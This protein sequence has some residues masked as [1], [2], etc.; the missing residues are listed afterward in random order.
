M[1]FTN[2]SGF[3]VDENR[4]VTGNSQATAT[5]LQA[6]PEARWFATAPMKF[7]DL[8][9]VFEGV[10]ATGS[11][12]ISIKTLISHTYRSAVLHS[13]IHEPLYEWLKH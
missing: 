7:R 12:V 10:L 11:E 5:Y 1:E 13:V 9:Q 2:Q 6:H 4:V 3:S 8:A